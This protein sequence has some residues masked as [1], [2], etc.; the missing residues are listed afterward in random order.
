MA[1]IF[2]SNAKVFLPSLPSTSS[3]SS[4]TSNLQTQPQ[5]IVCKSEPSAIVI[6]RRTVSL[7][8]LTATAAFLLSTFSGSKGFSGAA[9]NAAILEAEDD[10]ELL[11]KV[12]R[13]RKKRLEKQGVLKSSTKEAAYLQDLV[14][15]LSKIGQAIEKNDLSTVSLVLGSGKD[16]EWIKKVNSALNKLSSSEEEKTEADAFSSSFASL[17]SSV[18]QNNIEASKLDFVA[19]ASAFEKWTVLSG[20]VGQLKGL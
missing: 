13:D 9:A 19:S 20:L 1:T 4:T 7:S 2:L 18:S 16:T 6:S 10:E 12:K 8:S 3:S 17:F 11:E 5:L 15:K 14:Y